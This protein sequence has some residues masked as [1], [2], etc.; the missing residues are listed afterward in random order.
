MV[1]SGCPVRN[2]DKHAAEIAMMALD[3]MDRIREMNIPHIPG[4]K[5]KLRVGMHTGK[6]FAAFIGSQTYSS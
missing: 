6:F 4:Q 2:G 5:M 1:V 3:L